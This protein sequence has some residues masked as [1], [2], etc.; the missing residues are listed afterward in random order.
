MSLSVK[1]VRNGKKVPKNSRKVPK[2]GRKGNNSRR[3]VGQQQ[4]RC[5]TTAGEVYLPRTG[6]RGVPTQDRQER[7][8]IPR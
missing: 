3:G 5:R 4:E 2:N 6:R 7:W 8:Y 1:N